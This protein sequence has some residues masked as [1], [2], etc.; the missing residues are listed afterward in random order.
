M[1]DI[2]SRN[3]LTSSRFIAA[4][5]CGLVLLVSVFL[6]WL[7]P[8][9]II[10]AVYGSSSGMS[11]SALIGVAGILGGLLAAGIALLPGRGAKSAV[12]IVIGLAALGLLALVIFNGTLPIRSALV[13]TYASIGFG[14]YLYGL[15][16]LAILVLGFTELPSLR[17]QQAQAPVMPG[18]APWPA[19]YDR[20]TTMSPPR[21]CPGCGGQVK[22]GVAFCGAC[23]AAM[24]AVPV[25]PVISR[26]ACPRCGR[27]CSNAAAFCPDCGV[28]VAQTPVYQASAPAYQGY[29][30]PQYQYGA[31][32]PS[33]TRGVSFAW[34]L[35]PVF[36]GALGGIIAFFGVYKKRMGLALAMLIVG[37]V[38]T[39]I[40]VILVRNAI[41]SLEF[42]SFM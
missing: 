5:V 32:A 25:A 31:A 24:P 22:P 19:S 28:P 17:R 39:V 36:L 18:A 34:W 13:R 21:Y 27:E 35:L 11:V 15:A 20:A 10:S 8:K 12:H 40:S 3:S 26:P 16:G 14:V 33:Q 2:L 23:G 9:A 30:A 1:S 37:I 38:L 29:Q 42:G 6:P 7:A 4:C 41:N